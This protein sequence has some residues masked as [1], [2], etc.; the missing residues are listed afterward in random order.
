MRGPA[1]RQASSGPWQSEGMDT[2]HLASLAAFR[3]AAYT[4]FGRRRDALFELCDTLLTTGPVPSLPLLSVQPQH[5]RRWGSLY[6]A[7][8]VGEISSRPLERLVARHPL[9]GGEPIYA[10]DASV[11]ARCDAEASPERARYYHPS[12]HSAGQPIVAGWAYSWIAPVGFAREGW[13]APMS[14]RRLRPQENSNLVAAEQI[15]AF[16]TQLPTD[17]LL[18]WFVFDAGYDPVQLT[19]ALEPACAALLVRLRAGRCFY[20]DPIAQPKTGRPRR[21]GH[22]FACDAPDTWPTPDGDLTVEDAQYGLVRVRAWARLHPKTQ[23]E[24][25]KRDARGRRPIV[26]GTLLL[27]EVSRLPQQTREPQAL[28][29]W[30]HGPPDAPDAEVPNL[31]RAWRAYVR[32]FDVE[33]TFRFLK[34]TLNWTVPRVR[35]PEQADRWT[36]LVV[37]AYTQLRLARPLVDDQRLPWQR[38]QPPDRRTPARVRRAF[39]TL[40]PRLPALARAPKPCGRSPGRPNGKRSGR[41]TRYPAITKAVLSTSQAA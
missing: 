7:L 35:H 12:R 19:Q 13:T 23:G 17:S 31:D 21:H 18:P 26:R 4:A 32:R 5:Q 15:T 2:T 28:W 41:A 40:L 1:L 36:W 3:A 25:A 8:A 39:S 29:L 6:D 10:V 20:A 22:K 24:R 33:H 9:A 30:W 14:V 27:V 38:P 16:L 37:L 11:W 34:Q